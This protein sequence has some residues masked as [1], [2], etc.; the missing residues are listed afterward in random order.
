MEKV[1]TSLRKRIAEVHELAEIYQGERVPA[2]PTRKEFGYM[3]ISHVKALGGSWKVFLKYAITKPTVGEEESW[4]P[5]YDDY[6]AIADFNPKSELVRFESQ[7]DKGEYFDVEKEA[8]AKRLFSLEDVKNVLGERIDG[9]HDLGE[10]VRKVET[11]FIKDTHHSTTSLGYLKV[12]SIETR[13]AEKWWV[14]INYGLDYVSEFTVA[15]EGEEPVYDEYEAY[16]TLDK[17]LKLLD[18]AVAEESN[19]KKGNGTAE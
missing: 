19:E 6:N 1:R 18:F 4:L 11:E 5:D 7:E 10:H 16:A 14:F 9:E 8:G 3:D 12:M 2:D 13:P 15:E 17:E